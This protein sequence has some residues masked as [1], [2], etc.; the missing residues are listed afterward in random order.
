MVD[1]K[2][3]GDD[4]NEPTCRSC[5][6]WRMVSPD[7]LCEGDSILIDDES[8][9][10]QTTVIGECRRFPPTIVNGFLKEREGRSEPANIDH[11]TKFPIIWG[12]EFCGEHKPK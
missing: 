8:D 10:P 4:M 9:N 6:F 11:A 7:D 12:Y 1:R 3:N 2:R 5:I